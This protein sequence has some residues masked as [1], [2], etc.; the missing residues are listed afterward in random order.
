LLVRNQ[1]MVRLLG[2]DARG[3]KRLESHD[4]L[5]SYCRDRLGMDQTSVLEW[6][7]T[8]EQMEGPCVLGGRHFIIRSTP[9]A[10]GGM[11]FSFDDI[12]ER[13]QDRDALR[14]AAEMLER[15][16]AERTTALQ[17]EIA[18]RREVEACCAQPRPRPNMPIVT[19]R[20]FGRGQRPAATVERGAPVRFGAGRAPPRRAQSGAGAQTGV[21][22]DLVE[23]LLEALFEISRL[24]AGAITPVWSA[25]ELEQ[26][27][28]ALSNCRRGAGRRARSIFRSPMSGCV[29][30]FACCVGSCK[31][32]CPTRSVIPRRVR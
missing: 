29:R 15:R 30:T 16:V 18:E 13:V 24:D 6:R 10:P 25:I 27:L 11:A 19:R 32:S 20:A 7:E 23:D 1:G 12:T 28:A 9:L 14:E 8:G 4:G 26:M 17:A 22:L 31:I 2:L 21:A 3:S 5:L